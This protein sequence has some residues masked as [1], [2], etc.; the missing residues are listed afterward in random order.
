[1]KVLLVFGAVRYAHRKIY[2]EYDAQSSEEHVL[3]EVKDSVGR[4]AV[5]WTMIRK[6]CFPMVMI[7]RE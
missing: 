7:M 5:T 4:R 1:M 3:D 2:L 6:S